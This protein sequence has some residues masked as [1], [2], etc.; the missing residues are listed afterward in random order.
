MIGR[1]VHYLNSV[2]DSIPLIPKIILEAI[3]LVVLFALFIFFMIV[4]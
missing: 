4:L 2:E 3:C 1:I